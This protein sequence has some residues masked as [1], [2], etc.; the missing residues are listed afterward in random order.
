MVEKSNFLHYFVKK[1]PIK[2]SYTVLK[3]AKLTCNFR[4]LT[5]TTLRDTLGAL[6]FNPEWS[7]RASVVHYIVTR[8]RSG[9][10]TARRA[11]RRRA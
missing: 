4:K 3:L 5:G 10:S 2:N 7:R 1:K 9:W 8:V 6:W 11:Q